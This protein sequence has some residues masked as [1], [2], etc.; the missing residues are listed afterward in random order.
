MTL[1]DPFALVA[2]SFTEVAQHPKK[3]RKQLS[4]VENFD[5]QQPHVQHRSISPSAFRPAQH[6]TPS[7]GV[8]SNTLNNMLNGGMPLTTQ[9]LMRGA[10]HVK[11]V[12]GTTYSPGAAL[13]W[14]QRMGFNMQ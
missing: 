6:G 8:H 2:H 9:L 11:D 14:E 4:D 13:P 10:P 5:S 1:S 7:G 3:R 12:P